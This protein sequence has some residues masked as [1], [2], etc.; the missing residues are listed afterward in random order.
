VEQLK[1]EGIVLI[2]CQV[3]TTHLESLGATMISRTSFK[4]YLEKYC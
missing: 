3:Y 1:M 4:K 2:D